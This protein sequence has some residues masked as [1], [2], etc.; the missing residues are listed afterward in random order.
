[1][2][3]AALVLYHR[4]SWKSKSAVRVPMLQLPVGKVI[5]KRGDAIE[6]LIENMVLLRI[7]FL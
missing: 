1:M 3:H 2:N 7:L 5:T 4:R 6:R